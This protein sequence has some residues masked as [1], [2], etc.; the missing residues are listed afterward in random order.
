MAVTLITYPQKGSAMKVYSKNNT[1]DNTGR[2][3]SSGL[4]WDKALEARDEIKATFVQTKDPFL[5]QLH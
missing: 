3:E 5:K 2:A 1:H 4:K